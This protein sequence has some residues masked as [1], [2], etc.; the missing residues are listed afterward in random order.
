M[1][2]ITREITDIFNAV[3]DIYLIFTSKK[4]NILFLFSNLAAKAA[5]NTKK[6]K[7]RFNVREG[8]SWQLGK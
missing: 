3:D 5:K 1:L 6:E 7:S 4:V 2:K 8:S